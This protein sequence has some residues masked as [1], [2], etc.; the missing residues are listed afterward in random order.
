VVC[1]LSGDLWLVPVTPPV[2]REIQAWAGAAEAVA[3]GAAPRG[4][5][6]AAP[7]GVLARWARE[8]S[9]RGPPVAHVSGFEFGDQGSDDYTVWAGG[10]L[11]LA[12]PHES[13]VAAWFHD[14][15]GLLASGGFDIGRHRGESAGAKWAAQAAAE[16]EAG[17]AAPM[18][19]LAAT[20]R[21]A[22]D[23]ASASAAAIVAPGT[24]T[25]TASG[26]I[27]LEARLAIFSELWQPRTVAQFNGH[28]PN[29]GDAATAQPPRVI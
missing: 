20:A 3:P 29:T 25:L 1:R 5:A 16:P 12:T 14:H 21:S 7:A 28:T 2:E 10:E 8:A 9:M 26:A 4:R 6:G 17:P 23:A 19:A 11:V 13:K 18:A 27:D 15:C 22:Q 24:S